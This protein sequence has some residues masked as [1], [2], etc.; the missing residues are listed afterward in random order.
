MKSTHA[1]DIVPGMIE[2]PFIDIHTHQ[3][4]PLDPQRERAK[5]ISI[6]NLE[7]EA[8]GQLVEQIKENGTE[9]GRFSAGIHPYRILEA[10]EIEEALQQLDLLCSQQGIQFVGECGLDRLKGPDLQRQAKT[11]SAQIDLAE[12]YRKP[13]I[14]HCVRAFDELIRI[15]K[16]HKIK[17]PAIIHG[18]HKSPE[19]AL[20]LYEHGFILSFGPAIMRSES[21]TAKAL[22]E[23]WMRRLPF[24]LETDGSGLDIREIYGSASNLLKISTDTLKDAIFA[25]WEKNNLKNG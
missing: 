1:P 12:Q 8:Y 21:K 7:P 17:V 22:E 15:E 14:I 25:T 9:A 19:M 18:F 2:P 5:V 11:F 6:Y 23:V 4:P 13:L 24:F 10:K 20:Q 3:P 16:Q